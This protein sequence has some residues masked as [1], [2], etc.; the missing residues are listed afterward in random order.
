MSEQLQTAFSSVLFLLVLF[1]ITAAQNS[2]P[3][4]DFQNCSGTIYSSKE[5][6]KRARVKT[7][8]LGGLTLT[9]EARTH[10]VHGRIVIEAVLCRTGR[11]TDLRVIE[12]LP[13]GMTEKAVQVVRGVRFAPAEKTWHTVSQRMRFEFDLTP[14]GSEEEMPPADA[15]GRTVE[16][17][18]IIGNRRLTS[19]QIRAWIHTQ[20]GEKFSY[21]LLRQD[22][23]AI[24]GSGYFDKSQTRSS[25][26]KGVRDG[27]VVVFEV[28]ELP[29]I[30]EVK[31]ENLKQIDQAVIISALVKEGVDLRNGRPFSVETA[32]AATRVIKQV[33]ESNGQKNVN[34]ELR[35]ENVSASQVALTFIIRSD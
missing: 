14:L 23:K 2:N 15:V 8:D 26:E 18:D 28:V 31:F 9:D 22:L 30:T 27:V 32:E 33:L 7:S 35:V 11:V 29:L 6:T 34:V 24:R 13:Y 12:G 5:V 20:P 25:I 1:V 17:V 4:T 16:A 10:D 21:D 19:E 3:K